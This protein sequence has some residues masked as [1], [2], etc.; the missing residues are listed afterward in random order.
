M[1]DLV[2]NPEDRFSQN[3]A[4][5]ISYRNVVLRYLEQALLVGPIC[6]GNLRFKFLG[7]TD[8]VSLRLVM[9]SLLKYKSATN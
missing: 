1:S 5:M 7:L 6:S 8:A 2:G 3:E 4:Q 9:E